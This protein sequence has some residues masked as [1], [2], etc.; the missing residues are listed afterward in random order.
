MNLL[1][2]AWIPVQQTG[3]SE[4]ITLQQLLCGEKSGEL[5]LPRDDMEFACLQLLVALTQVMFTPSDK[6][7]LVRRIKKPLTLQE[8][9]NGCEGK[10][11]WFDVKH[12]DTPFMQFRGVNAKEATPLVKLMAGVADGTNKAFINPQ[13]LAD[14]L[15]ASCVA[16][17]LYNVA[18]NCP[19]MGGG[20]KSG[21][22]GSTPISVLISASDLRQA[23]WHNVLTAELLAR[24]MPWY[25]DTINQAPNYV[26]RIVKDSKLSASGIGLTRGLFWQPAR[27][28]L[29]SPH[30]QGKCSCCGLQGELYS[31]FN[32]EK[33][34]YTITGVWPHPLSARTFVIKQGEREE[35]FPSFTTTQP[36]WVHLAKLVAEIQQDKEGY[37]PVPVVNQ[38]K[39]FGAQ[40]LDM[41]V[42]GYRN[43]KA[44]VLERRHEMFSLASGWQ[45]NEVLV[46][47]MI[48]MSQKYMEALFGALSDFCG[49]AIIS[50][51]SKRNRD[52]IREIVTKYTTVFYQQTESLIH[53]VLSQINFDQ[54]KEDLER[55]YT[56]LKIVII[57]LFNQAVAAYQQ[58]PKM[59]KALASSRRLLLK[60][61]KEL[62]V[63]GGNHESTRTA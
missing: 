23:L 14:G 21:M 31:G 39:T 41:I 10:M 7:A 36:S 11:A 42:G 56:C 40:R 47:E 58:E 4:K 34:N 62:E 26:S 37:Q 9:V 38:L 5:C 60:S 24:E 45:D 46:Y 13:G 54:P 43:N 53:D 1:T 52:R 22:R 61:L 51:A 49:L 18:Y 20:F 29:T 3:I 25:A 2:D 28:E 50:A 12:P 59:L 44:T 15:C 57:Q 63:Q 48:S 55:L 32:K 8:Y 27:F 19:S 30:E 16:I 35:K 6:Q 33:F 17:A